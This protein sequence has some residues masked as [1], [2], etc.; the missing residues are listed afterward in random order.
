VNH[1]KVRNIR[2][3]LSAEPDKQSRSVYVPIANCVLWGGWR[4]VLHLRKGVEL[5]RRLWYRV[6]APL[7]VIIYPRFHDVL[8]G[9]FPNVLC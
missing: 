7:I 3:N 6:K 8:G 4:T 2:Y 5:G 1:V 9:P